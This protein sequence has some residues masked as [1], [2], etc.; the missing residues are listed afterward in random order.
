MPPV[1][2]PPRFSKPVTSSAC[3]QWARARCSEA[4]R[5]PFRCLRRSPHSVPARWRMP[6]SISSV[7]IRMTV[8]IFSVDMFSFRSSGRCSAAFRRAKR[9]RPGTR[10]HHDVAQRRGFGR[11]RHDGDA[12]S[13][14]R[15]PVQQVV[16]CAAADDVQAFDFE[17]RQP[18]QFTEHLGVFRGQRVEYQPHQR[19]IVRRR[20]T[21]CA[22]HHVRIACG[23]SVGAANSA[24]SGSITPGDGGGALG[25]AH[26]LFIAILPALATPHRAAL[27]EQPHAGDVLQEPHRAVH[28]APRW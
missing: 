21:P 28:A 9:P 12:D 25:H 19:R 23:M 6:F 27:F 17:R 10:L 13:V 26:D 2:S 4:P 11:A 3:Q 15:H 1:R 8:F 22:A 16:L 5:A 20:G 24:A 7:F 18:P 14:G